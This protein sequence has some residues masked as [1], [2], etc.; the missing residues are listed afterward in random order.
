MLSWLFHLSFNKMSLPPPCYLNT[1]KDL[2]ICLSL[3]LFLA[4]ICSCFDLN[5]LLSG[6]SFFCLLTARFLTFVRSLLSSKSIIFLLVVSSWTTSLDVLS[7]RRRQL[8]RKPLLSCAISFTQL[9][10]SKPTLWESYKGC[11]SLPIFSLHF[12]HIFL[13]PWSFPKNCK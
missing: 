9:L 10:T 1:C 13:M 3:V 11:N 7:A 12:F 2:C 8:S 6:A 4:H 5:S